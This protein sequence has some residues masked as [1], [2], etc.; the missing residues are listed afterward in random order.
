MAWTKL[1]WKCARQFFR[2]ILMLVLIQRRRA[3]L[4]I[5]SCIYTLCYLNIRNGLHALVK[6][7]MNH[8]ATSWDMSLS[9]FISVL[10]NQRDVSP[11]ICIRR[12]RFKPFSPPG[13]ET[14]YWLWSPGVNGCYKWKWSTVLQKRARLL[15]TI[16]VKKRSNCQLSSVPIDKWNVQ[17]EGVSKCAWYV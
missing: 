5:A 15:S 14:Q 3:I 11:D 13:D 17:P 6:F 7:L 1:C 12:D 8:P 4:Y 9:L 16:K 2:S 10:N